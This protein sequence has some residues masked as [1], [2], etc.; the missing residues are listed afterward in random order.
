M[1]NDKQKME[2]GGEQPASRIFRL[3]TVHDFD[4]NFKMERSTRNGC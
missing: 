3:M 2:F 4:A 1:K